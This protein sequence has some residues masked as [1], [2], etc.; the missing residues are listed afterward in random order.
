MWKT[1]SLSLYREREHR[2]EGESNAVSQSNNLSNQL[3]V[4]LPWQRCPSI[5]DLLDNVLI[6]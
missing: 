2:S 5:C 6:L 3:L 1:D 4:C